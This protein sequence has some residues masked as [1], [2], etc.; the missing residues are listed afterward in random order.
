[1]IDLDSVKDI[2]FNNKTVIKLEDET[3]IIWQRGFFRFK[4]GY[5][6]N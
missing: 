2:T 6:G 1:M 3:G 4:G 5:N